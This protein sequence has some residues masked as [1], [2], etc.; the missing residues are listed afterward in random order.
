MDSQNSA[1]TASPS[2]PSLAQAGLALNAVFSIGTG[3]LLTIAPG[4]VG[5]WLGVDIDIWLR[6]LG[7]GLIGHAAVLSWATQQSSIMTW[8]KINL[9]M[10]A[11]Y[12]LMM[13]GV[14]IFLIDK[15]QGIVLA[16]GV[17]VGLAALIQ[18]AGLRKM[19][20]A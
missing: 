16:D 11:P 1:S 6:L 17:I 4:T 2:S 14:A 9:L 20:P 5:G 19:T 13:L 18:F 10:I 7:I 8:T 3:L 12:P 15:G